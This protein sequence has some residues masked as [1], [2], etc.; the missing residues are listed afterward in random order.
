MERFDHT[1]DPPRFRISPAGLDLV[2]H[3]RD[4]RRFTKE[5][6]RVSAMTPQPRGRALQRLLAS[7]L[8][9]N[10]WKQDEPVRTSNEEIDIV[11][12]KEKEYYLTECK[13]EKKPIGR[14]LLGRYMAS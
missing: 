5:F 7:I 12:S 13:W 9:Q 1:G 10:G 4:R 6:E 8:E 11:V 3:L 2:D 14:E